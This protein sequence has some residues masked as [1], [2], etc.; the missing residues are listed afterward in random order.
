MVKR[1]DI[2][3]HYEENAELKK[4]VKEWQSGGKE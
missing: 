4:K 3:E 2:C 1:T